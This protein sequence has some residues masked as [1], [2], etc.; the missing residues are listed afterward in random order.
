MNDNEKII[1][2]YIK[3]HGSINNKE[4]REIL[5]LSAPEVRK[6]FKNLQYKNL[7]QSVGSNRNRKYHLINKRGS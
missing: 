2:E 6:I 1:L 4:A 5:N 7:I 3:E